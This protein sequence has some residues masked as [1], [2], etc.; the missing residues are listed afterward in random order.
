MIWRDEEYAQ[1]SYIFYNPLEIPKCTFN[2]KIETS[3][4]H[5]DETKTEFYR[6]TQYI[7]G[8]NKNTK[9]ALCIGCINDVILDKSNIILT[10][11]KY[12]RPECISKEVAYTQDWYHIYITDE[13]NKILLSDL[14]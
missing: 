11:R 12:Y 1:G 10:I 3:D 6:K 9:A 8:S 7:K 4:D 5:D 13:G 14:H 2:S